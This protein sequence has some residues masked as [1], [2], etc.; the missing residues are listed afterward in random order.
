MLSSYFPEPYLK[1]KQTNETLVFFLSGINSG[2][3]TLKVNH[4]QN[5]LKCFG[6]CEHYIN[7]YRNNL[8]AGEAT[9]NPKHRLNT[10][11]FVRLITLVLNY[12]YS[13]ESLGALLE[14]TNVVS[15]RRG[16]DFLLA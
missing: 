16:S 14:I 10:F 2:L 1:N 11:W 3:S 13:L 15:I 5:N 6:I 9:L 12:G 8:K 4:W 7:F